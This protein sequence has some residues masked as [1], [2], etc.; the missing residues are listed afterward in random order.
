MAR[1]SP[2]SFCEDFS[3]E[4]ILDGSILKREKM[5]KYYYFALSPVTQAAVLMQAIFTVVAYL[6]KEHHLGL[7]SFADSRKAVEEI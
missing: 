4:N 5:S 7:F 2:F 6:P 1:S 3:T